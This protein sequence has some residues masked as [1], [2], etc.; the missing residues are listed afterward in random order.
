MENEENEELSAVTINDVAP[1]LAALLMIAMARDSKLICSFHALNG[2]LI[3]EYGGFY[4]TLDKSAVAAVQTFIGQP[5]FAGI[6]DK[7]RRGETPGMFDLVA[8][9]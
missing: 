7:L 1:D 5:K 6:I 3:I 9:I 2:V 8:L 4:A